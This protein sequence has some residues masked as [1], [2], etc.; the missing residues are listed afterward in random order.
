MIFFLCRIN[1]TCTCSK[2]AATWGWLTEGMGRIWL[3]KAG[4][5][6]KATTQILSSFFE[7]FSCFI[8]FICPYLS[9][10]LTY[11]YL[12]VHTFH[13]HSQSLERFLYVTSWG[14]K[15][16]GRIFIMNSS[17]HIFTLLPLNK[18]KKDEGKNLIDILRC[19]LSP[20]YFTRI[21]QNSTRRAFMPS[22]HKL[23]LNTMNVNHVN[24]PI[25]EFHWPICHSLCRYYPNIRPRD[26]G[27]FNYIINYFSH[28]IF[29]CN[30]SGNMQRFFVI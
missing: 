7:S 9:F 22:S 18:K 17:H 27:S 24:V 19:S 3:R 25:T 30:V 4:K 6:G 14:G 11:Y 1:F 15:C 8:W 21:G 12:L 2:R 16:P 20:Q 23:S 28:A 29:T 5:G 13:I 10:A 26:E